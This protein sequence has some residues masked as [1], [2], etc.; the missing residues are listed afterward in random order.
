MLVS[1]GRLRG[2]Q[3]LSR[4]FNG[5]QLDKSAVPLNR[6]DR[7]T[8]TNDDLIHNIHI[9][10]PGDFERILGCRSQGCR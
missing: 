5:V 3:A 10:G 2:A 8:F 1:I 7:I 9:F 4:P 6:G